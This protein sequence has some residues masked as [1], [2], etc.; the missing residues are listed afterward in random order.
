MR[1]H[2]VNIIEV[3]TFIPNVGLVRSRSFSIAYKTTIFTNQGSYKENVFNHSKRVTFQ[4]SNNKQ[5]LNT[6]GT[7]FKTN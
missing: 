2:V 7:I 3:K 5:I 6:T 4:T 1:D